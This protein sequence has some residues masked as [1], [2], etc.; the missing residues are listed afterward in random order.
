VKTRFSDYEVIS[1]RRDQVVL[2]RGEQRLILTLPGK[3][4]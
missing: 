1:I 4:E 3:G 2:A